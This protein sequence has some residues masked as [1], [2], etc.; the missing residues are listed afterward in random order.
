MHL[1]CM[2]VPLKKL[3]IGIFRTFLAT[4][5]GLGRLNTR[6][7]CFDDILDVIIWH[8]HGDEMVI[9]SAVMQCWAKITLILQLIPSATLF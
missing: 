5:M 8:T 4:M 2:R 7:G 6:I 9:Y 3:N 1:V